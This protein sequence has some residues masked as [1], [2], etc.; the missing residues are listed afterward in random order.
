MPPPPRRRRRPVSARKADSLA[1]PS[2]L[3]FFLSAAKQEMR[4]CHVTLLYA[5]P[6]NPARGRRKGRKKKDGEVGSRDHSV[7]FIRCPPP[8]T[9]FG[10]NSLLM[11]ASS[12]AAA[13]SADDDNDDVDIAI[14]PSAQKSESRSTLACQRERE[15]EREGEGRGT[16]VRGRLRGRAIDGRGR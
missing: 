13:P 12:G 7:H 4:R 10:R 11:R 5:A 16:S 14:A 6:R 8:R 2:Y 1:R 3:S 9:I 15:R